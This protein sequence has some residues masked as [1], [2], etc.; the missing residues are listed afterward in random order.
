VDNNTSG[1][2]KYFY[3]NYSYNTTGGQSFSTSPGNQTSI[4]GSLF[5]QYGGGSTISSTC[6]TS[7]ALTYWYNALRSYNSNY[8]NAYGYIEFPN[9][10]L[11]GAGGFIRAQS[12]YINNQNFYG[13]MDNVVENDIV[14][15]P[16]A[17]VRFYSSY[18]SI[19]Q[20]T[21]TLY[22]VDPI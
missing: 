11:T 15:Y 18:G 4:P 12:N 8:P 5:S 14:G 6:Y 16:I 19:N 21:F 9:N 17:G 1:V 2:V 13:S 7:G 3:L 22:G 10:Y 20:G